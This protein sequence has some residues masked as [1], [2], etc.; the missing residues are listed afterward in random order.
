MSIGSELGGAAGA[1]TELTINLALSLAANPGAYVLLLGSGVSRA[2]GTPT[3]WEV[4]EELICRL[5]AAA[6]E[7]APADPGSWYEARTGSPP[8]YAGI[9]ESVAPR[10]AERA[11]LLA[12]FFQATPEER[13][14]GL[15]QPTKAHR[16]IAELVQL[17][18]VR[19]IVTTNFD[20]LM[21]GA[22]SDL[23]I[24]STVVSSD[25]DTA[26]VPP[27]TQI[28]CLVVKAHGDYLDTRIRNTA[29]EVAALDP[30]IAALLGSLFG[31]YGLL[32]A[33]WSADYDAGLRSVLRAAGRGQYGAYW[34]SRSHLGAEAASLVESLDARVIQVTDADSFF[35][36]LLE[37]VKSLR[38]MAGR[39]PLEEEIAVA[40]AKR[41]LA[42]PESRIALNDL[43]A[44]E[45]ERVRA[46]A[47]GPYPTSITTAE[48]YRDWLEHLAL[49]SRRLVRLYATVGFWGHADHGD[50]LIRG[51]ERLARWGVEGGAVILLQSRLYPPL[52]ALCA[53][54]VA[55]IAARNYAPFSRLLRARLPAGSPRYPGDED[56]A[57]A[58]FPL[59]ACAVL[60]HGI[61]NGVLNI[62]VERRLEYLTP[63]SI[64]VQRVLRPLLADLVP[65]DD[66]FERAFDTYEGLLAM[67]YIADGG[68]S[69]PTGQ[70][71]YRGQRSFVGRGVPE[72]L[73]AEMQREGAGWAPVASGL[74]D[75]SDQAQSAAADLVD[76]LAEF[77]W[78]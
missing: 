22:L 36:S 75:S 4:V 21:E 73:R 33:G 26:G 51:L 39:A 29:D 42:A 12:G 35:S 53:S 16:A 56:T 41:Y 1:V 24:A 40:T 77:A 62:G 65:G 46:L 31:D 15:K 37:A 27:L 66:Q 30:G 76:R 55:A 28:Q 78:V 61:T 67:R 69:V 52:L 59:N 17:G 48:E 5:A 44:A 74:F 2:A 10:Q 8:T 3:G 7:G 60:D 68:R 11:G 38:E 64:Y 71:A 57:P 20:R 32:I 25:D 14:L 18:V 6:G 23:G 9:I 34:T 49:G 70:Y 19:V 58:T 72:R 50:M 13:D 45:V 63:Q 47:E 43:V 54:G